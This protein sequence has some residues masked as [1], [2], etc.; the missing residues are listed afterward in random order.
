MS[1][2]SARRHQQTRKFL[3]RQALF[4]STATILLLIGLIF[5]GIPLLIK[6]SVLFGN[7][8]STSEPLISKDSLAPVA[9]RL[10]PL[11]EATN[12]KSIFLRGSSEPGTVIE[13]YRNSK[14]LKTVLADSSGEFSLK[15]DLVD[16]PNRFYAK[17]ADNFGN[18][19]PESTL[20][21]IIFDQKPPKVEMEN[22]NDKN[23]ETNQEILEIKGKTEPLT[24]LTLNDRYVFVN[25]EGQFTAKIKLNPG[26][27]TL[28]VIALDLAGNKTEE[29]FQI[30]YSP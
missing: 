22:L 2:I 21:T 19:S 25:Q 9:P 4:F 11:E 3:T 27:N 10:E 14:K 26:E 7:F 8:K 6:I 30:V 12:Q 20:Q 18:Q 13:V 5:V 23:L 16:G 28:A 17:A 24:N 15:L 1:N 29:K